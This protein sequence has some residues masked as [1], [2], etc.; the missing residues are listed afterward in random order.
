MLQPVVELYGLEGYEIELIDKHE[1]GRNVAYNCEKAGAGAR[2]IR[3]AF[4]PDRSREDFLGEVEYVK[5][6]HENGGDV[7]N[8]VCSLRGN[9]LEELEYNSYPLFVCL[10]EKAKGKRLVENSY[11]YRRSVPISEYYYNCG[12]VLGKLHQLSK[13]YAPTHRRYSYFDKYNAERINAVIPDSSSLLKDKMFRL[14]DNLLELDRNRESFGMVHFDFNDGNYA[15]DFDTGQLTVFDFDDSCFGWYMY[16]LASLWKSGVGWTQFEQDAGK[17]REFMDAYFKTALEGYRSETVLEDS[18]LDRLPLFIQ[19]TLMEYI[20]Y[21]FEQIRSSGEQSGYDG[22][23]A[24]SIK[25][26]ENDIPYWGFFHRIYSCRAPFELTKRMD[27]N[28]PT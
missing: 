21:E 18:L 23:L 6:L 19:T 7:A 5:Y 2:I 4:L 22:Q 10:F 1:G 11:Q 28:H 27:P 26:L 12:K 16:D 3:I 20:V 17:R 15:I 8:V 14:L 13:E 25:C 24:Y 9:L